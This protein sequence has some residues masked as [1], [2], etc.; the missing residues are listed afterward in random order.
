MP[1]DTASAPHN[2]TSALDTAG[3]AQLAAFGAY[4]RG[5]IDED[6][7]IRRTRAAYA[8]MPERFADW[9]AGYQLSAGPK[10]GAQSN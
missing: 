3:R 10:G 2:G 1:G 6:E 5:E 9:L 7:M 4:R 8:A